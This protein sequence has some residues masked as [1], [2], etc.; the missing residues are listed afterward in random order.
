MAKIPNSGNKANINGRDSARISD[1]L[2]A[3]VNAQEALVRDLLATGQVINRT[4]ALNKIM[5]IIQRGTSTGPEDDTILEAMKDLEPG[6]THIALDNK[7]DGR[8][9]SQGIMVYDSKKCVQA[10][11]VTVMREDFE[12]LLIVHYWLG[13]RLLLKIRGFCYRMGVSSAREASLVTSIV[14]GEGLKLAKAFLRSIKGE[15]ASS[16]RAEGYPAAV[17][18]WMALRSTLES[19]P[20][21]LDQY[22]DDQFEAFN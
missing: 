20:S 12:A 10:S 19:T 16:M 8:G 2:S 18:H 13:I 7:R 3:I 22:G 21:L 17:K 5:E 1:K 4:A 14:D 15:V 11:H 6:S 9:H